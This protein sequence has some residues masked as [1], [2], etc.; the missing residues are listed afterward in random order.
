MSAVTEVDVSIDADKWQA[1][2]TAGGLRICGSPLSGWWVLSPLNITL[3]RYEGY[4]DWTVCT[5]LEAWRHDQTAEEGRS[6]EP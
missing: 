6:Q 4:P 5:A 2:T 1:V 3:A